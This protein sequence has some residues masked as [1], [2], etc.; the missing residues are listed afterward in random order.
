MS[1]VVPQILDFFVFDVDGFLGPFHLHL[2]DAAFVLGA[3]LNLSELPLD[4]ESFAA[5]KGVLNLIDFSIFGPFQGI[6]FGLPS[7]EVCD[8]LIEIVLEVGVIGMHVLDLL[9]RLVVLDLHVGIHLGDLLLVFLNLER[10]FLAELA[11]LVALLLE[12]VGIEGLLCQF[13]DLYFV[14]VSVEHALLDLFKPTFS[15]NVPQ[16]VVVQV[17]DQSLY[18]RRL[19]QADDFQVF[20]HVGFVF[21]GEA[22]DHRSE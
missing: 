20:A 2:V 11:P 22:G 7:S 18:L 3:R 4:L 5:F 14:A 6:K 1:N 10:L 16:L 15:N 13:L 12:A 17:V 19:K 8:S 21:A 9:E